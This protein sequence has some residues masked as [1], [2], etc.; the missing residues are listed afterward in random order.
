[1]IA[2]FVCLALAL[3]A[4][5]NVVTA[6]EPA[7][8]DITKR[9]PFTTSRIHGT[10]GPPDP[11]QT[12]VVFPQA[13]FNE[14]LELANVPGTKRLLV[15]ERR[16]QVFTFENDRT[17]GKPDLLL[18]VKRTVYGAVAHPKFSDNGYVYVTS[19]VDPTDG[20]P[21]GTRVSRFT[22]KGDPP[23]ADAASEKTILEWPSGGHN[24]GCL[25][26]GPDGCLY[27]STGDG[28][29]INDSRLSGQNPND[30]LGSILRI[31]VDHAAEGKGYAIPKDNPYVDAKDAR[32]EVFA[33]GIR[34]TW[35][36]DWDEKGR[37]WGGDV[38]QDLWEEI[39]LIV[40]GG[41]YGWS[42][43]EGEAP[44]RPMRPQG[45]SEL[46]APLLVQPHSEFRSLTGGY[47]YR[48]SRLP[49][50]KDVYIYGDYDTGK[51]W[52]LHYDGQKVTRNWQ[53]AD[54]QLRII[55]FCEDADRELYILDFIGG[56]IHRLMPAPPSEANA[57]KFPT[58][59][60]ETGLFA[61]TKDHTP[62]A[63]LIPYSVNAPLWSDN[64]EK[65]RFLALPG[66]SQIEFETEV[67]PQPAPGAPPGWRFPA[68]TVLVK[69][70]AL[71]MEKGNLAS[72]RRLETRLLHFKPMPG[73]DEVGA[74]FWRGYT[75]IW[76]DDQTDAELAPADGVSRTYQIKDAS[77]AGGE[78]EQVWRY[79]SRSECT[80]C[81]TFSA[82]YALGVDTRQ[83]N[84][85]HDYGGVVANQLAVLD[86]LGIF[87]NKLPKPPVELPKLVDYRDAS[88]SLDD[89]ARSYLHSNCAHCHRKW[90][91]G[92]AEFQ[93]LATLPLAELGIVDSKPGQGTL[94]LEDPRIL[95]PGDPTR[96]LIA[97]RMKLLGP[98]RM[99]HIASN[100]VD[101]ESLKLIAEWIKQLP[102]E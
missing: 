10:P 73:T 59:L 44:F 71:E 41:N 96:S 29:G 16:G 58:K 88:H 50:L 21:T 67:Y 90:G 62:A 17:K 38:G 93:L 47:V 99:P 7:K 39:N 61:S 55:A 79:P 52:A 65:E 37:M 19:I 15:A 6:A 76:N 97:H 14:P 1:M 22:A 11:Y 101:E 60:S 53:L 42:I 64:A 80:M 31:D 83:M 82:K 27:I 4:I 40:S 84:K 28:S 94:G 12:E 30:L 92:N 66:D 18:D 70:F 87:K 24:G 69:T 20:A 5:A 2:R 51:I 68:D 86:Q 45:P 23:T 13:K 46:I 34:Q 102:K 72:K 74:Q 25:R 43:K 36:Y 32:P 48:G 54:T 81:H 91:G 3:V 95:I 56:K 63:G 77:V 78:R 9:V 33:Y 89:R 49:E 98:G 85:D 57:P 75:Y 100:V 8:F 26:F 35:K